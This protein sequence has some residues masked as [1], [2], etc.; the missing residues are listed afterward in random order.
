[1]T[2]DRTEFRLAAGTPEK[3]NIIFQFLFLIE[4]NQIVELRSKRIEEW[5]SCVKAG[6]IFEW[7]L[8]R[9]YL[10][11]VARASTESLL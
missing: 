6:K 9:R 3:G 4:D 10:D 5:Y 8:E 7:L 11:A 1:M 2:T